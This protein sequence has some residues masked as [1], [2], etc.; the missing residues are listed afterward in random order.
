MGRAT[1]GLL[2]APF[3]AMLFLSILAGF[4]DHGADMLWNSNA[5]ML[6]LISLPVAY[7]SA[8]IFGVP[9]YIVC[10][11]NGW[12]SV[13]HAIIIGGLCSIPFAS[14]RLFEIPFDYRMPSPVVKWFGFLFICGTTTGVIFWLMIRQK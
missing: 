6:F 11:R 7:I 1:N 2:I 14:L 9:A 10:R 8:L 5:I 13:W 3:V 4:I 12:L